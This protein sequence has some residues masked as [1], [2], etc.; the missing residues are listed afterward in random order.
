ME[1]QVESMGFEVWE[2]VATGRP[3]QE[4]EGKRQQAL[5]AMQQDSIEYA[6]VLSF[7]H[8]EGSRRESCP[9]NRERESCTRDGIL[10]RQSGRLWRLCFLIK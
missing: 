8:G 1:M 7:V 10:C 2:V 9:L 4:P 3:V 6:E 5:H